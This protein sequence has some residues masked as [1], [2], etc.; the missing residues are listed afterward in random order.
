MGAL[1][2]AKCAEA[3]ALRKAFPQELSGLYT[4]EEM[5]QSQVN[6]VV[7]EHHEPQQQAPA[8]QPAPQPQPA[9]RQTPPVPPPFQKPQPQPNGPKPSPHEAVLS[10]WR[11]SI[12]ECDKNSLDETC[13]AINKVVAS[14]GQAVSSGVL[15]KPQPA[16]EVWLLIK[17]FAEKIKGLG[18]DDYNKRYAAPPKAEEQVDEEFWTA[19]LMSIQDEFGTVDEASLVQLWIET[20]PTA[21]PRLKELFKGYFQHLNLPWP[22][23]GLP[24]Q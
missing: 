7:E 21:G 4:S 24:R 14:F 10:Q 22:D 11:G 6:V 12:I 19:K 18:W 9:P 1:M 3:L 16:R 2:L 15:V 8:P 5:E 17:E 23:D 13:A 20:R